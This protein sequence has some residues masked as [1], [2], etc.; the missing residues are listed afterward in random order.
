MNT[1]GCDC[2][3]SE[4]SSAAMEMDMGMDTGMGSMMGLSETDELDIDALAAMSAGDV[5]TQIGQTC[6]A[7]HTKYR[8][9]GN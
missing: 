1:S 9:E 7:C 8:A 2:T 5:F 3:G 4:G 6:S